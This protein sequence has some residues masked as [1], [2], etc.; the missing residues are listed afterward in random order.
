MSLLSTGM[1]AAMLPFVEVEQGGL[2][3]LYGG[4]TGVDASGES[5]WLSL[6][7]RLS[8]TVPSSGFSSRSAPPL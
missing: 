4:R 1:M 7:N 3:D 5:S 2:I 6:E 8:V